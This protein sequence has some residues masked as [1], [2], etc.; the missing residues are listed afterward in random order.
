MISTIAFNSAAHVTVAGYLFASFFKEAV[1]DHTSQAMHEAEKVTIRLVLSDLGL[2]TVILLLASNNVARRFLNDDIKQKP[3]PMHDSADPT[4]PFTGDVLNVPNIPSP[5]ASCTTATEASPITSSTSDILSLH[6]PIQKPKRLSIDSDTTLVDHNVED[7][8]DDASDTKDLR[9][10]H[11]SP[12]ANSLTPNDSAME[13]L[14]Q[15]TKPPRLKPPDRKRTANGLLLRHQRTHLGKHKYEPR[16]SRLIA[17]RDSIAHARL[18]HNTT[19]IGD[20]EHVY[21]EIL[22]NR[23]A[24]VDG[25]AAAMAELGLP[26]ML[27]PASSLPQ[28]YDDILIDQAALVDGWAAAMAELGLPSMLTPTPS[29]PHH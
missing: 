15:T 5:L 14:T 8:S 26:S 17:A 18:K 28:V 21:N 7:V 2:S 29:L 25:W 13:A 4:P 27:T 1:L 10:A 16:D 11:F 20:L 12:G 9:E 6:L 3:S 24:L 22:V 19:M 23:A